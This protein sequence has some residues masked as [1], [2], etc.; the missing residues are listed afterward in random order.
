MD[1]AQREAGIL[2]APDTRKG[3][4]MKKRHSKPNPKQKVEWVGEN[5]EITFSFSKSEYAM[6]KRVADRRRRSLRSCILRF[7]YDLDFKQTKKG[8]EDL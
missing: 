2:L 6:M 3:N 7:F 5:V 8:W 4:G 1:I